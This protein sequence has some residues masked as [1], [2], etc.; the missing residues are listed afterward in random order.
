[1]IEIVGV[2]QVQRV[3]QA[4]ELLAQSLALGVV[5]CGGER[6]GDALR[7]V[8]NRDQML[9]ARCGLPPTAFG[10]ARTS[11]VAPG[12]PAVP[13]SAARRGPSRASPAP[14]K[15]LQQRRLAGAV[16]SDQANPLVRADV[17]RHA[18]QHRLGT[19]VFDDR[20]DGKQDHEL[21]YYSFHGKRRRHN[22]T[23]ALSKAC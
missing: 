1:M 13:T 23:S 5:G 15:N 2:V 18:G 14:R 21:I 22:A 20:I 11:A 8:G 9:Q 16:R 3:L 17:E 19:E 6:F 7:L 10:P 12:T 4:I